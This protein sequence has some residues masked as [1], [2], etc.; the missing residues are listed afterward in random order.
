MIGGEER[1]YSAG[2]RFEVLPGTVHQMWSEHGA[3]QR[4]ETTPAL[5]TERFFEVVWGIQRAVAEGGPQPEL[6][7][8]EFR[9][10]FRLA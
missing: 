9:D 2:D 10:E 8:E 5:K 7:L 3:R 6:D 4:W 1:S